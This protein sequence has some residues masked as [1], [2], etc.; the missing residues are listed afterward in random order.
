MPAKMPK[1]QLSMRFVFSASS[2]QIIHRLRRLKCYSGRDLLFS[3][4]EERKG[5][6]DYLHTGM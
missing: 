6:L 2:E 4:V 5:R 3:P 1:S